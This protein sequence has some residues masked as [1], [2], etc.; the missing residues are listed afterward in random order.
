MQHPSPP[1]AP[2]ACAARKRLDFRDGAAIPV[3][4]DRV[5]PRSSRGSEFD[6]TRRFIAAHQ[7]VD[8]AA[9]EAVPRPDAIHNRDPVQ[10]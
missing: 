2:A 5:L 9:G 7:R 4:V 1:D 8:E 3:A 10:A 6:R